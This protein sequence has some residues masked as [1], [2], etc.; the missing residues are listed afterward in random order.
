MILFWKGFALG[1]GIAAPVGAIGV[2]CIRKSLAHGMSMGF[3][4]GLGAATA[5]A[6][7]GAIAAFGITAIS[8][9]LRARQFWM[10]LLGGLFLCYLGLRTFLSKPPG[11]AARTGASGYFST[12]ISTFFLTLTN[13]TTVISFMVLFAGFGVGASGGLSST[14]LVVA[15]VFLGSACWWLILSTAV[16]F[17]RKAVTSN[18]MVLVNRLSGILLFAFGIYALS[19]VRLLPP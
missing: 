8:D 14:V 7:Y 5:D 18:A 15:G 12:Y 19:R 2:L 16:G 6:L 3:I 13:P 1:F 11:E 10:T 17:F 9:F 4:A